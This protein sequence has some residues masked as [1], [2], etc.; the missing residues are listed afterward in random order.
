MPDGDLSPQRPRLLLVTSHMF[1]R[2]ENGEVFSDGKYSREVLERYL[3]V[4]GSILVAGRASTASRHRR[5]SPVRG[6]GIEF[7]ELPEIRPFSEH[8]RA[9]A[10]ERLENAARQVDAIIGRLPSRH[11][12][13]GVRIA[14]ERGIPYGIEL[15]GDPWT[16]LWNHGSLG[17]KVLALRSMLRLKRIV[18]FAPVVQYVTER[19]L[20]R[21]YPTAGKAIACANVELPDLDRSLLDSRLQRQTGNGLV[22]GLIGTLQTSY[23]GIDLA[24]RALQYLI[25]QHGLKDLRLEIVGEGQPERW[26]RMALGMG[27][28]QNVVFMGTLPRHEVIEWLNG[29]DVYIQPSRSEGLP[30]ALIEAMSRAVPCIGSDVGGIPELLPSEFIHRKGDWQQLAQILHR[31]LTRRTL[32][33]QAAVLCFEK[34]TEFSRDDLMR[35]RIEFYKT[36]LSQRAT[37]LG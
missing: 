19:Y 18:R 10:K 37:A 32:A 14:A 20:Q 3:S 15:V 22:I 30:R 25:V 31:L 21:R 26:E 34:A 29:V 17:G 9:K 35:R 33:D 4:F 23:K 7:I 13:I 27:I 1:F 11:G 5:P 12:V 24:F 8:G 6:P 28:R 36:I 2:D 16:A